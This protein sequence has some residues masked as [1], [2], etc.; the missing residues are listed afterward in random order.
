ML[1]CEVLRLRPF[2]LF[3]FHESVALIDV[4]LA[5]LDMAEQMWVVGGES[6]EEACKLD[7]IGVQSSSV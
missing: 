5:Q 2:P 4:K 1:C 3:Y 6:L 7:H